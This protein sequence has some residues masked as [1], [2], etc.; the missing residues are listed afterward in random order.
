MAFR[1]DLYNPEIETFVRDFLCSIEAEVVESESGILDVVI[2]ERH[3]EHFGGKGQRR[4][5]FHQQN[6]VTKERFTHDDIEFTTYGSPLLNDIFDYA[7][8]QG[9]ATQRFAVCKTPKSEQMLSIQLPS[10][11]INCR[12]TTT[13]AEKVYVPY[14]QFYFKISYLTDD[15]QE[16][17]EVVTLNAHTHQLEDSILLRK[18]KPQRR[19]ERDERSESAKR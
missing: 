5:T 8:E 4:I 17:V 14:F 6:L 9:K 1:T 2:P 15:K 19:K 13:S 10:S 7:K 3:A 16:N 18:T 11:P 12:Y